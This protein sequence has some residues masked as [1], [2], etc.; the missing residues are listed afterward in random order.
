MSL[1]F[2]VSLTQ[3][4]TCE[5]VFNESS[6]FRALTCFFWW[7]E[8]WF[9]PPPHNSPSYFLI[10]SP[11]SRK[12]VLSCAQSKACWTRREWPNK[13]WGVCSRVRNVLHSRWTLMIYLGRLFYPKFPPI[14][15]IT[16]PVRICLFILLCVVF[17]YIYMLFIY[18]YV[19][20]YMLYVISYIHI[21]QT[22]I[23]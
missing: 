17:L 1:H 9:F 18:I 5:L 20:C 15:S 8:L 14:N 22:L 19:I 12:W 4:Y 21:L 7:E 13:I 23:A 3:L 2:S 16:L 11:P 6:S 10:T